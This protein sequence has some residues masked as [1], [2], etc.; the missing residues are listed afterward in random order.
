MHDKI[1]AI[2]RSIYLHSNLHTP[3][4]IGAMDRQRRKA[5]GGQGDDE[6]EAVP[7]VG[8]LGGRPR[9]KSSQNKHPLRQVD[10]LKDNSDVDEDDTYNKTPHKTSKRGLADGSSKSGGG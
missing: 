2:S 8:R 7:V 1:I 5:P 10:I 4:I 3:I 6:V 9:R